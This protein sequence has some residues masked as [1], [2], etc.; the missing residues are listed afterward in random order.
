VKGYLLY[1]LVM[2]DPIKNKK[3]KAIFKDRQEIEEG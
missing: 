3:I 1:D 2:N